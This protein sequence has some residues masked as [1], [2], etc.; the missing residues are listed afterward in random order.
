MVECHLLKFWMAF[1]SPL[2]KALNQMYYENSLQWIDTLKGEVTLSKLFCLPSEKGSALK[3]KIFTV[4]VLKFRTL[5]IPRHT[6]VAGYYGFT[7][8]VRESIRL[9]V[10]CPSVCF[11]FWMI[12]W[13][14]INGFSPNLV[15]ALILWFWIANG[16]ISSN[17]Y[18]VICPR[19]AHIFVSRL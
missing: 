1:F 13:V 9:S 4:N 5:F 14:N 15:C 17:F 16:Q 3:R 7:L 10:V 2:C 12:T 8:V 18:G 11:S 6:I 19:Q